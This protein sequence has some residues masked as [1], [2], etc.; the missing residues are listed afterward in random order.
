VGP[1][2]IVF[3]DFLIIKQKGT[4]LLLHIW[5]CN[6]DFPGTIL[7]LV[8]QIVSNL[9]ICKVIKQENSEFVFVCRLSCFSHGFTSWSTWE[10]RMINKLKTWSFI[11]LGMFIS[12]L[13]VS[14]PLPK[15]LQYMPWMENC[16]HFLSFS[17]TET[18]VIFSMK[19]LNFSMYSLMSS[20]WN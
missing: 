19:V 8:R 2:S 15:F 9:I 16:Y 6:M 11:Y 20:L 13:V 12:M 5:T 3:L 18:S 7:F 1:W 4:S 10:L 14:N 17:V